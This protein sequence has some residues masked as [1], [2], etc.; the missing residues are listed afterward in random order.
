MKTHIQVRSIGKPQADWIK[1]AVNMYATR[2]APFGKIELIELPEGHRGSAKPDVR[3][4]M[5]TEAEHLLGKLSDDA[6]VIALDETGKQLNSIAFSGMIES[7]TSN[8]RS[9]IFLIG[10]S[11]GLDAAVI[12]RANITL[13]LGKMTLPHSLARIVLLEQIYRAQMIGEGRNYHK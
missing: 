9:L 7:E 12:K 1:E 8:G 4:A 11:W 5:Q 3:K 13:S 2:C 6:Y 10:G